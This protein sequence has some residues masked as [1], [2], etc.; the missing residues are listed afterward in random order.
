MKKLSVVLSSPRIDAMRAAGL[1]TDRLLT[2]FFDRWTA[3]KPGSTAI[4][5]YNGGQDRRKAITYGELA[6]QVRRF[7]DQLSSLGV[8]KGDVISLQLP[9]C[10]QF[11]AI[12]L[13]CIRIGAIT[14]PLVTIL[15]ERELELMLGLAESRI[16]ITT[17]HFRGFDHRQQA[18]NLQGKVLTLRHVLVVKEAGLTLAASN[19]ESEIPPL[20]D[21]APMSPND[22]VEILYT[23]G[24]TGEPKGVM[25]TSNTLLSTL[26]A[27]AR[28]FAMTEEDVVLMGSP[29]AH[30]TGFIYGMMLPMMLGCRSVLMDVWNASAAARIIENECVTYSMGSTPFLSDLEAIARES[31]A[32]FASMRVF[33]AAGSP[34]PRQLVRDAKRHMGADVMSGWGMT[35]NGAVTRTLPSDPEEKVFE[36]DG[37]PIEG[38]ELRVVDDAGLPVPPDS[39]GRLQVRGCSNFVGYLKRPNLYG[40]N[41]DGWFETGDIARLDSS[42]FLRITGRSKDIII[43]GG[44]NI[45]VVEIEGLLFTHPAIREVAIVGKPHERLGEKACAFIVTQP[46]ATVDLVSVTEFLLSRKVSKNYL[47]EYV[48]TVESL[49]KTPSGKVQKFLLKTW[50]QEERAKSD[51]LPVLKAAHTASRDDK[52]LS[53]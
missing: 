2:D 20:R 35:E 10:W 18:L 22:V 33:H 30:Q 13:A 39:E 27:Y 11:V 31:P 23:S 49:P 34:I 3:A 19:G 45:P 42:N 12:H 52:D 36:T 16:L 8:R 50:A 43:R 48:I 6:G 21:A 29:L 5:D 53:R 38:T 37:R 24:T 1:W 14:N 41:E 9:N 17:D 25:H 40:T 46:G 47:P 7:S 51:D 15:R 26:P 28:G 32:A 44:E 4:V